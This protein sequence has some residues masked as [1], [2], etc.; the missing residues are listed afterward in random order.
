[1]KKYSILLLCFS[2]LSFFS[3]SQ[4]KKDDKR[5]E[6]TTA[7]ERTI[8]YY[9]QENIDKVKLPQELQNNLKNSSEATSK[10]GL[11]DY[12][13]NKKKTY[14]RTLFYKNNPTLRKPFKPNN[15]VTPCEDNNSNGT[16]EGSNVSTYSATF[17]GS[18]TAI[19]TNIPESNTSRVALVGQGF[20]PIIDF[21][22]APGNP[23]GNNEAS[24]AKTIG[25]RAIRINQNMGHHTNNATQDN[26]ENDKLIKRFKLDDKIITLDYAAVFEKWNKNDG[27]VGANIV[28]HPYFR[29]KVK[30]ASTSS[31]IFTKTIYASDTDNDFIELGYSQLQTTLVYNNWKTLTIDLDNLA[32]I[33]DEVILEMEV[34]DCADTVHGGYVYVDNINNCE[35]EQDYPPV[36]PTSIQFNQEDGYNGNCAAGQANLPDVNWNPNVSHVNWTW[37]LGPHS[38][39]INGAGPTTP[40]YF[41]S[42]NWT[43]YN[44]Y[45]C[46]TTVFNDGTVC[47]T[48]CEHFT[49][50]CSGNGSGNFRLNVSPNPAKPNSELQFD[51]IDIKEVESIEL[52]D[53]M[54]TQRLS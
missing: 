19:Q 44:I 40:I 42:G 48:I 45:I 49:L 13:L 14:L 54:V 32:N 30:K 51:G 28:D 37:S 9:I 53:F 3:Y 4:E 26:N 34:R 20:D 12:L 5:Q 18:P 15:L 52:F 24:L 2:L 39:T 21:I 1:M 22:T 29:V 11:E 10:K 33:G 6:T 25:T 8:D 31:T 17:N 47:N 41:P 23:H 16:F 35:E 7:I 27:H 50:D 36:C 43:G 38:G 46:A